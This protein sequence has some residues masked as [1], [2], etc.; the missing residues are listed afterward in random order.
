MLDGNK[1]THC[2]LGHV[3]R[4]LT[5]IDL[6]G[7]AFAAQVA[8]SFYDHSMPPRP[9]LQPDACVCHF[10][11]TCLCLREKGADLNREPASFSPDGAWACLA[12]WSHHW[13]KHNDSQ[14]LIPDALLLRRR[15]C[16]GRCGARPPAAGCGCRWHPWRRSRRA[17]LRWRPARC[18]TWCSC[19]SCPSTS[20]PG[21]PR[22]WR[23]CSCCSSASR[24]GLKLYHNSQLCVA[25]LCLPIAWHC[26]SC[27]ATLV[28]APACVALLA[29]SG[30]VLPWPLAPDTMHRP[31]ALVHGDKPPAISAAVRLH[32]VPSWLVH[33]RAA[34]RHVV[35]SASRQLGSS[36]SRLPARRHRAT[37][38]WACQRLTLSTMRI[39]LHGVAEVA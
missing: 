28:R 37:R 20:C 2:S 38:R 26:P 7:S 22:T 12:H 14:L 31:P 10:V 32:W 13:R 9:L 25:L 34:S 35:V 23:P 24:Q 5:A 3:A 4:Q 15:G 6:S 30:A 18:W 1:T 17:A 29:R 21:P 11:G 16:R 33:A 27:C 39:D 19:G 36:T 8:P